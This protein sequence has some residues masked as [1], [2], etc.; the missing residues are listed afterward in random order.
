MLI[1]HV[2]LLTI[3]AFVAPIACTVERGQDQEDVDPASAQIQS[4]TDLDIYLRNTPHSPLDRLS[5]TA[6]QRFLESLVFTDNGLGSYRFS[7]LEAELSPTELYQ[8]LSLFGV[9]RTTP[10][11]TGSRILSDS[12]RVLMLRKEEDH[13]GYKCAGPGWCSS[14]LNSICT[15]NC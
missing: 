15:S 11:L 14:D 9:E 5:T 3:L 8:I 1:K 10:L 6:K 13:K 7:D 12:D 4:A 2:I